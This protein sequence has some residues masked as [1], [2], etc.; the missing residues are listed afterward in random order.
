MNWISKLERKFGKYAIRNLMFYIIGLNLIG[1]VIEEAS[2]QFFYQYL[3]LDANAILHGQIWRIVTFLLTPPSGS[4]I[5]LVFFC[6]L[7]HAIGSELETIW[8]SFRFNLYYFT[9]V[10][11]HIVAAIVIYLI[12]KQNL[13]FST[14]YL[15]LSLF[16]A[17]GLEFPEEQIMVFFILPIKMKWLAIFDGLYFAM[18]VI[19]G[20]AY[21]DFASAAA[22][23]IAMGN[24]LLFFLNSRQFSAYK[25]SEVRRKK[26]F[27]TKVK[28][29]AAK[30]GATR[31]KCAICG[32]TELDGENL[33]FRYC[34]KCE[35]TYEYC[36]D[37]LYTHKHVTKGQ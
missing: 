11:L 10:L 3:I 13:Y 22:A 14:E 5:N 7:Y 2:P 26:Q 28:M 30:K 29:T 23:L 1:F 12:T 6:L 4:L 34:S 25:P 24:F 27:Q 18:T 21:G 16:L 31:H 33:T 20:V 35:G 19:L 8:G 15:N 17:Y 36:Q 9:G 37:H 32:R